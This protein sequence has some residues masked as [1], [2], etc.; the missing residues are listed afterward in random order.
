MRQTEVGSDKAMA[1][2]GGTADDDIV[3]RCIGC[4]G[5]NGMAAAGAMEP[6]RLPPANMAGTGANRL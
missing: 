3:L 6:R 5:P 1:F 2:N 4:A